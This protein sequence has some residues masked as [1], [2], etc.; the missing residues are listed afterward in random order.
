[1]NNINES[2]DL[3]VNTRTWLRLF[4]SDARRAPQTT[5]TGSAVGLNRDGYNAVWNA[6]NWEMTSPS[7][8]SSPINNH[9]PVFFPPPPPPQRPAYTPTNTQIRAEVI[10]ILTS[11]VC[12]TDRPIMVLGVRLFLTRATYERFTGWNIAITRN[13]I[14]ELALIVFQVPGL[15]MDNAETAAQEIQDQLGFSNRVRDDL[16]DDLVDTVLGVDITARRGVVQRILGM[17]W[18]ALVGAVVEGLQFIWGMLN[19]FIE[20]L[21]DTA[22]FLRTFIL[23]P[24]QTI[25]AIVDMVLSGAIFI[26]LGEWVTDTISVVFTG[27]SFEAGQVIGRIVFMVVFS[28]FVVK[29]ALASLA[30]AVAPTLTTLKVTV[31]GSAWYQ[32]LI[33]TTI[34]N[35]FGGIQPPFVTPEG[36]TIGGGVVTGGV[37]V[38]E[39]ISAVNAGVVSLAHCG[40]IAG[41]IAML[42]AGGS[43]GGSSGSGS[44]SGN[45]SGNNQ[46]Q[47]RPLTNPEAKVLAE[48]LG[49]RKTN[50]LSDGRAVFEN[51]R[52]GSPR[53]ITADRTAHNGGVWKGAERVQ[54]LSSRQTRTGTFDRYLNR[55]GD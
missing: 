13:H 39:V 8:P 30:Q 33:N 21:S 18:D 28:K 14:R 49:Y 51:T 45:N 23:N 53:F 38:S 24:F 47:D 52:R 19:G 46:N 34:R 29:P 55:I 1:V 41:T 4:A 35:P 27:T 22:G 5:P 26:A 16:A 48:E 44:G 7:S 36:V 31:Q 17:L 40:T 6:G 42:Q 54:D 15:T 37:T 32:G 11:D 9:H 25:R 20:Q 10:E 2:G 12:A 43:G 3:V 50:Y